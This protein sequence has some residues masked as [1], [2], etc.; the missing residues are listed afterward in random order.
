MRF[1]G[2]EPGEERLYDP[3][4][5]SYGTDPTQDTATRKERSLLWERGFTAL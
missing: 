4:Q 1:S 3:T 2:G 5:G